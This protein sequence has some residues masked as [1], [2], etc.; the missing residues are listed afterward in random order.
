MDERWITI[1]EWVGVLSVIYVVLCFWIVRQNKK[2]REPPILVECRVTDHE[3]ERVGIGMLEDYVES[4][5]TI[6]KNPLASGLTLEKPNLFRFMPVFVFSK[7]SISHLRDI[8]SR[9]IILRAT[10]HVFDISPYWDYEFG[11]E[12]KAALL[13]RI[14]RS[15][16]HFV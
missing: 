7:H 6:K 1:G 14:R 12:R 16:Q 5:K 9:C 15:H 4:L 13:R 2:R 8:R 11:E 10:F 3:G